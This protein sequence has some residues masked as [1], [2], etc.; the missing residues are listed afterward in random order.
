MLYVLLAAG[1]VSKSCTSVKFP[2]FV[3]I[4]STLILLLSLASNFSVAI[5]GDNDVDE[6]GLIDEMINHVQFSF[7]QCSN[8]QPIFLSF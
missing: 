4:S 2:V 8:S 1:L 3:L 6:D 7:P 5:N